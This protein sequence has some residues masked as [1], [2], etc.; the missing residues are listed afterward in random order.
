MILKGINQIKVQGG[1]IDH[2]LKK[3]YHEKDAT[4]ANGCYLEGPSGA[5]DQRN[6]AHDSKFEV[7]DKK[8]IIGK[9]AVKG[10]K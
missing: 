3:V 10:V 7:I 9:Q 4:L 1:Q 6:T 5:N 2:L 8:K